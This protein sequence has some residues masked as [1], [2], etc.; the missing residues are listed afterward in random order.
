MTGQSEPRP[1]GKSCTTPGLP[2]DEPGWIPGQPKGKVTKAFISVYT[3]KLKLSDTGTPTR[4]VETIA[5]SLVDKPRAPR[6]FVPLL[7]LAPQE[8]WPRVA[9]ESL[10]LSWNDFGVKDVP[11]LFQAVEVSIPYSQIY[12][13][14]SRLAADESKVSGSDVLH[15]EVDGEEVEVEWPMES[16]RSTESDDGYEWTQGLC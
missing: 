7:I 5:E 2:Q 13:V 16:T 12:N 4:V 15:R 6:L 11:E 8:I 14:I 1:V 10:V 9:T 3:S